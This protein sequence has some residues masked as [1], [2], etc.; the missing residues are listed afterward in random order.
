MHSWVRSRAQPEAQASGPVHE[1]ARLYTRR[2]MHSITLRAPP[3]PP[4]QPP[5][6]WQAVAAS[7][8]QA[9]KWRL[10][11]SEAQA[12][13]NRSTHERLGGQRP[14]GWACCATKRGWRGGSTVVARARPKSS[15]GPDAVWRIRRWRHEMKANP[16]ARKINAQNH[17]PPM[18]PGG[19][20]G[21]GRCCRPQTASLTCGG[22]RAQ[23]RSSPGAQAR[24]CGG[25]RDRRRP[26]N[27]QRRLSGTATAAHCGET[28]SAVQRVFARPQSQ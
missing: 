1:R 8:G 12:G 14:P 23:A 15:K 13:P 2:R 18:T 26:C 9:L 22:R 27:G 10:A 24:E 20:T 21:S 5:A 17:E 4:P 11:G 7:E 28:H 3:P 25:V 6:R 19:A 16:N